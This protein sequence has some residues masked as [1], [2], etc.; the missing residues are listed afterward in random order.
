MRRAGGSITIYL[1]LSLLLVTGMI[2]TLTEGARI[3]AVQTRLKGLTFMAADS[4]FA[5]YST[6]IFER[7]GIMALWKS[8]AAF[9]ADFDSF[10]Q[11][12]LTIRDLDLYRDADLFLIR[13]QASAVEDVQWLT[14]DSGNPFI[15][16]VCD[17]MEYFM[18]KEGIE[19]ILSML[20]VMEEGDR[21]S[22]FVDKI[23]SYK[24]VFLKVADTVAS[25]QQ[26]VDQA[27]SVAYNPKTLLGNMDQSMERYA[28]TGNQ[29]YIAQFNANYWNLEAG[30]DEMLYHMQAIR[31]DSET[32]AA[33]AAVAQEAV[34]S[35]QE[36]LEADSGAYSEETLDAIRSQLGQLALKTTDPD[37]DYYRVQENAEAA[38]GYSRDLEEL[39][40]LIYGLDPQQMKDHILEYQPA[41]SYYNE[42]FSGFDLDR[43]GLEHT[44]QR[45]TREHAGFLTTIHELFSKG[46]LR[47]VAGNEISDKKTDI[48]VLPSASAGG[49]S[50]GGS[51]S[52]LSVPYR[53][54]LLAAYIT[55]H[56]GNYT[57]PEDDTELTYEAE[58]V[59]GGRASDKDNLRIT[60]MEL[61]LLR[62]GLNMISLMRDSS[63][64]EEAEV[65][66]QSIIGFTGMEALVEILKTLIISAWCLAESICDVK[67][68]MAG[69]QVPLIKDSRHWTVSM[70]GLKN[71]N[72]TA[73]PAA[74][75][76][77]G[78][79]Y[80]GY[81]MILLLKKSNQAL[82]FR[83]MDLIQANACRWYEPEFRMESCIN[84]V[85][86]TAA[87]DA[88]QLFS[89]FLFVK[90]LTGGGAGAYGFTVRQGYTYTGT[91]N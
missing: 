4:C 27:R 76:G 77:E 21:I 41:V 7:Y 14:D 44:S 67:A 37:G 33:D 22:A 55:S 34:E 20:G 87:F 25:I 79:D 5:R 32:F 30:R 15:Q 90:E 59:L 13:H 61:V 63:K 6:E 74:A 64:M 56:F 57:E 1:L 2:F 88:G 54:I 58:Y 85:T 9:T 12:N 70:S 23:N 18:A 69:E 19:E 46:L 47:A 75:G 39:D 17:Y 62:S 29:I 71:F 31:E 82:A 86:M 80:A 84:R 45:V 43:L 91:E 68:L 52:L 72:K 36:E 24:D 65:L 49:L 38:A 83:A 66:A 60:A 35:L 78:P 81:L 50:G 48:K 42:V 73:I 28:Q 11:H 40:P 16:Q 51:D 89:S 10:L 53:R 26:H 3:H 8:E